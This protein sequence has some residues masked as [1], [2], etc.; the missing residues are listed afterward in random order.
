MAQVTIIDDV[1]I[2]GRAVPE[3]ISGNRVTVCLG[4]YSP[5]LGQFIR[6]YPTR[7]KYLDGETR[8]RRWDIIRVEVERNPHDNRQESWKLVGSKEDWEHIEQHIEKI[9]RIDD[10]NIRRQIVEENVSS[11]VRAI[12]DDRRSLGFVHPQILE[13]GFRKNEQFDNPI[14]HFL[15]SEFDET[16]WAH[17]KRDFEEVPYVKYRCSDCQ[18]KQGYHQQQ[19]L[20]WGFFE[21]LR[22]NPDNREQVWKNAYFDDPNYDLFF[23]VG[24]QNKYRSSFLVIS[25]I[26]I[27]K[28][29]QRLLF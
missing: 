9:G 5:S 29:N 14:Q 7:V 4:G 15:F 27:K 17:T 22:K 16:Q 28:S 3:V 24:N 1:I 2:L 13:R 26:R 10:A 12:E 20:E 11:C 23:F 21:W 19:I 6:L 25:V 8:L 18:M